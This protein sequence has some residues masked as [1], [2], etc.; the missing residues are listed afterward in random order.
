MV[1][2]IHFGRNRLVIYDFPPFR[3]NTYCY[4][5]TQHC[6]ISAT[7]SMVDWSAK[8]KK[9]STS[10]SNHT[11]STTSFKLALQIVVI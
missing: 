3:H 7:V 5:Q 2:V 8:I 4:R 9:N 1:K 10:N 11:Y 6:S